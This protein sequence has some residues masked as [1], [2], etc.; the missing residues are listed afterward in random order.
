MPIEVFNRYEYKYI[1]DQKTFEKITDALDLH[2]VVDKYC[3]NHS[4]YTIANLYCDTPDDA[5]IRRSLNKPVYKEKLRLRSYGTV[6]ENS[7]FFL[8]IKKKYKGLVNKRRTQ[9][10][11]REAYAFIEKGIYPDESRSYINK[12]VLKEIEYLWERSECLAPKVYIAYDR[13]AYFERGNDDLRISFDTNLRAR[14]HDLSFEYGD[15]GEGLIAPGLWVMEIKTS[16]AMPLWLVE[17]IDE[18]RIYR[19]SFSKY[20]TEYKQ[21]IKKLARP[22]YEKK[23]IFIPQPAGCRI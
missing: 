1:I 19:S 21:Y 4:L 22:D 11:P 8:E 10:C 12:Q 17:L 5:L 9:L 7:M 14:R 20:G 23:Y 16:R 6:N 3:K 15:E 13:L 2:M 18:L